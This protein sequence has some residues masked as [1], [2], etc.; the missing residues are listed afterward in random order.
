MKTN[1]SNLSE[2]ESSMSSQIVL[3]LSNHNVGTQK[4]QTLYTQMRAEEKE[5]IYR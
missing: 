3:F 2:K 1:C 5:Y 4:L